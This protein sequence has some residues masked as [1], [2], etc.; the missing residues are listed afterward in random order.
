MQLTGAGIQA[1][2]RD[3]CRSLLLH[4]DHCCYCSEHRWSSGCAHCAEGYLG[5]AAKV[6]TGVLPS[7]GIV[8]VTRAMVEARRN[9]ELGNSSLSY[10]RNNSLRFVFFL[11]FSVH[12]IFN[13]I[14]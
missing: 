3:W 1:N 5:G 2:L 12:Q 13:H 8:K 7:P 10:T 14:F 6:K 9:F 4:C 11:K